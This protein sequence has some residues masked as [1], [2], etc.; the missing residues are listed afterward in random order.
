[1]KIFAKD[2]SGS[3]AFKALVQGQSKDAL[4]ALLGQK[5]G[6]ALKALKRQEEILRKQAEAAEKTAAKQEVKE[7]KEV[8]AD[9]GPVAK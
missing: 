2:I 1:M 6:V 4:N 3:D 9:K 8:K 7:V 5:P